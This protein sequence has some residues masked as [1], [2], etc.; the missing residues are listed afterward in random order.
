MDFLLTTQHVT[1]VCSTDGAVTLKPVRDPSD[2]EPE[3]PAQ[4]RRPERWL[5][6]E[7]VANVGAE[8]TFVVVRPIDSDEAFACSGGIL[9]L[10]KH[11]LAAAY[12]RAATYIVSAQYTTRA[13]R[14]HAVTPEQ[15][16]E[17]LRALP[18]AKREALGQ[19]IFDE[20]TGLASPFVFRV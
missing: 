12:H 14:L 3:P 15:R 11:G 1:L 6:T 10:D 13:G 17:F 4:D 16:K 2:A 19:V 8:A 5:R 9:N 20:S 7:D 18:L